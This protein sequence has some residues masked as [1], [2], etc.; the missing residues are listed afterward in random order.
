MKNERILENKIR[1]FIAEKPYL[2]DPKWDTFKIETS[3][4]HVLDEAADKAGL[5]END[6]PADGKRIDLALRSNTHLLV[7]EFMRPGKKADYEHLSRCQRYVHN[8]RNKI[9]AMSALGIT[10]VT[11]LIVADKLDEVGEV[12]LEVEDLNKM[13]ILA[14]TWDAL[15]EQSKASWR[16]YLEIITER[17]PQDDRLQS[18]KVHN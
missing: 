18:L 13:D 8:I 6:S 1:D 4:K 2:L 12:L 7:V 10:R 16:E 17:V 5:T 14:Y 9:K 11:G 3:L 15:L